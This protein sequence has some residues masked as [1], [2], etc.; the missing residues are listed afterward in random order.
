MEAHGAY[1][2]AVAVPN[3]AWPF[4]LKCRALWARLLGLEKGELPGLGLPAFG[5][6][7]AVGTVDG[8]DVAVVDSSVKRKILRKMKKRSKYL[9]QN[10]RWLCFLSNICREWRGSKQVRILVL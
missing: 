10:Q 9:E 8:I 2:T 3:D 1:G 7:V 5:L 6:V 4:Q